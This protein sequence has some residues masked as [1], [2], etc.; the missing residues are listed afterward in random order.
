MSLYYSIHLEAIYDILKTR[1]KKY[2][3]LLAMDL[4][5]KLWS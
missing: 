1:S 3:H 4:G 2:I 5:G